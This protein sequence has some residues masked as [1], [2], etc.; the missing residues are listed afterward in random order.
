M[1]M[2][3][4]TEVLA[5]S[6]DTQK[7]PKASFFI[8][9]SCL[10]QFLGS[11]SSYKKAPPATP[12]FAEKRDIFFSKFIETRTPATLAAMEMAEIMNTSTAKHVLAASSGLTWEAIKDTL[13]V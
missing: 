3:T 9:T 2:R 6:S 5:N 11:A 4:S 7:L 8:L 1:G 10:P 12:V 13:A